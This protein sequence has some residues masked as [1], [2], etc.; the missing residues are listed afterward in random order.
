LPLD[1]G[2]YGSHVCWS[3][4]ADLVA[5]SVVGAIGIAALTQVRR[6]RQL[7]LACLPLLLGV[8]QLVE[9]EVWRGAD[10]MA[11][12]GT[13]HTAVLIWAAIA[14]PLLPAFVPP[15]VLCAVWPDRRARR[16]L[17]PL[18]AIGLAV[19]AVLSYAL[20]AGP[21]SADAKGRVLLYSVQI[22][23]GAV[24]IAGYLLA[25]LG[26]PM[27][28]GNREL[29]LFGLVGATGALVCVLV[30]Q[31]AFAS[32]WCA[33]AAVVSL[34]LVYWLHRDRAAQSDRDDGPDGLLRARPPDYSG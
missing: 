22:P 2:G 28:S 5:G 34:I 21:V 16:R 30:W 8:H 14:F 24:V 33:F 23:F 19:S 1:Q 25:T 3:P 13:A 18:C 11:A 10:G 29:R 9:S 4:T 7:P 12:P 17:L 31:L 15:A 6:P 26:A 20:A 32:T 27:V